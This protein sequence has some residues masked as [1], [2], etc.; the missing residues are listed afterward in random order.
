[1]T[2]TTGESLDALPW[3]DPVVVILICVHGFED[4][5]RLGQVQKKK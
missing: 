1:M 5:G 2:L 4:V 3:Y